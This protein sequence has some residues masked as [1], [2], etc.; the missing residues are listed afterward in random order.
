MAR[1]ALFGGY[2]LFWGAL[3][4]NPIDHDNW[5]LASILPLALVAA[6]VLARRSF[7]LSATS[8]SLVTAFL[9][10]HTV[11]AHYTYS[12]VPLGVWL[13][14]GL[15]LDRNHFDRIT[16]FAFGLLLTYPLYEAFERLTDAGRGLRLYVT[17]MTQLGLAGAWE[18]I[19]AAVAQFT[20]PELGAAFLGSQGDPWAAQ[21]HIIAA[22]CG[23]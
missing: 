21:H 6:L 5:V 10:L 2:V 7:P 4:I 16:H 19:E 12:R 14:H 22:V 23:T 8:C 13:Q 11:G 9:I 3:G 20:H 1:A 18:I 17:F 15:A